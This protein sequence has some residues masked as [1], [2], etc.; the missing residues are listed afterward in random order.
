MSDIG[1]VAL[2]MIAG[3]VI[4]LAERQQETNF[5]AMI[6]ENKGV[7]RPEK[8]IRKELSGDNF[9]RLSNASLFLGLLVLAYI[10]WRSTSS[11]QNAGSLAWLSLMALAV[12]TIATRAIALFRII[13]TSTDAAS[14]DSK[15][16]HE[17]PR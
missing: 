6:L 16:V 9:Y 3:L 7:V 1:T 15:I 8:E 14:D 4:G 17:N 10:L 11:G 2:I 12:T 5:L 13:R